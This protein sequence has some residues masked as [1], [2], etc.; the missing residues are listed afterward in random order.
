MKTNKHFLFMIA[1][2]FMLVLSACSSG[3]GS[4]TE[5]TTGEGGTSTDT[6]GTTSEGG[7]QGTSEDTGT[8]EKKPQY[9]GNIVVASTGSPTLF[10]PYYSEDTA[11]GDIGGFM[12]NSLVTIDKEFNPVPDLAK[13]WEKSDDGLTWTF[14][15]REDVKWHDGK[16]FTA[17]DVV[18]SYNIPR[19][20]EYTGPRASSFEIIKS[21][22]A[23]DK[24]TVKI[25]LSEP[26]APFLIDT[27]SYG[28]LPKHILGDTP[29]AKMGKVD[30]NTKNPIGTGPYK[31]VE[32][33][34]GQYVKLKA[35]ED[36]Y[37]GKP[38]I[39]T[40]TYKI[41]PDANSILAQFKAGQVDYIGVQPQDIE[42]VQ[43]MV[44]Q[45]K[46]ETQKTVALSYTYMG[47]NLRLPMFQDKKVRQAL[48]MAIDRKKLVKAVLNG[49]GTVA[50]APGS[51]LSWA[52][53]DDV[54]TFPYNP[55][56]AKKLLSEAGWKDTDGDG[57]REKDGKEFSFVLKTNQGNRTRKQTATVIQQY[58]KEVGV[59]VEPKI[60][61]WS[62]F[63][64][65]VTEEHDYEA[66]I[67]GWALGIDP[68]PSDLWSC[69]EIEKGLNFVAY[70]NKEIEPLMEKNS[71]ITDRDKR[72]E[73]IGKIMA[74]IAE[75]QPYTFLY[76]PKDTIAYNPKLQ[77]VQQHA[78]IAYYHINEWWIKQ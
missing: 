56:K 23:P 19:S 35:N 34:D 16:P 51:P 57:I 1:L 6:E 30:F 41:I 54:P 29:I 75:D 20:K 65:Q 63:I 47:Y 46:A 40:I 72:A 60:V 36:Y 15:L 28:I 3:G 32:W 39:N 42:T 24:Y 44:K 55:E 38:Y 53:N 48:T 64:Q 25:Q 31:F 77:N 11:S 33:K 78:R 27:C 17:E 26:Y 45:G 50:N 52:Y 69:D 67:L 5:T 61:E 7:D 66:V 71:K 58:L 37:A 43:A 2:V 76:Y 73:V 13:S 62:A 18:F 12:Y 70:C 22:K 10:N 21:I 74:Q 9:G 68:D 4:G 49:Q 8:D 59:K 14:H